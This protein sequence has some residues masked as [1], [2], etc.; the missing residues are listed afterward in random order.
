[1]PAQTFI[2]LSLPFLDLWSAAGHPIQTLDV[3]SFEVEVVD[4]PPGKRGHPEL[5]LVPRILQPFADASPSSLL[6][7]R[8]VD[9]LQDVML[10]IDRW[11][12]LRGATTSAGLAE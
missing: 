5:G 8:E 2:E 6:D 11:L 4:S 9:D 7:Q 1:M 3:A 12:P 10:V